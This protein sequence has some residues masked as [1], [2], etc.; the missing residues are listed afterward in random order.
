MALTRTR[1]WHT[2]LLTWPLQSQPLSHFFHTLQKA[3]WKTTSL[4]HSLPTWFMTLSLV[5]SVVKNCGESKL[6]SLRPQTNL[7]RDTALR[8][9]S[10]HLPKFKALAI[11]PVTLKWCKTLSVHTQTKS[12]RPRPSTCTVTTVM[13]QK[14]SSLVSQKSA[15]SVSAFPLSTRVLVKA[16]KANTWRQ[17]SRLKNCLAVRLASVVH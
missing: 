16:A 7:F 8:N 12:S 5:L 1:R 17:S 6:R 11:W 2:T 3:K 14:K 4:V 9:S 10:H 15:R 13:F